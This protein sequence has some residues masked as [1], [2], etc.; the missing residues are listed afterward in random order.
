MS[1]TTRASR[2]ERTP[3]QKAEEKRIREMHR[4][5]PIR[6]TPADT[7]RGSDASQLLKHAANVRHEREAQGLTREQLAERAGIDL[8]TLVRFETGQAFNPTIAALYR[9]AAALGRTLVLGLE[10]SPVQRD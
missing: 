2:I 3:E 8:Q 6:E 10:T 1:E 5:N 4:Q 9:I 7:L